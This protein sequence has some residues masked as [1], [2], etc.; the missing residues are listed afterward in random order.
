[1]KNQTKLNLLITLAFIVVIRST[2]FAQFG[3]IGAF[4]AAGADDAAKLFQP[5]ISPYMNAFGASLTGGWYNTAETHKLGG[6]DITLTFNVAM[7]PQKYNSFDISDIDLSLLQLDNPAE[8]ISPTIAGVKNAG[9]Q[10][11]YNLSGF[12][13]PAFTMPS[14]LN[15]KYVPSPML[16]AGLGLI[17]GT[18]VIGRYIPTIKFKGGEIGMWGIGGKHNIKQWIPGLKKL[19][20]LNLSILYGYTKL[21]MNAGMNITPENIG[22]DGLPGATSNA[23]DNQEMK[24]IVRSSTLNL[25]VSANLPVVCFYG[26]IGFVST[27]TTLKLEGDYPMVYLDGAIPSVQASVDPLDMTIKPEK[28]GSTKV[29]LNVGVRFKFAIVTVHFDYTRANYNVLTAGFGFSFR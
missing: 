5:Y 6:F 15:N 26:G 16:Q 24:M 4:M 13:Q 8:H 3:D 11:D 12:T 25:L 20:I 10:M 28:G 23:W 17:K 21:H 7:V 14:G 22:A 27:K 2:A 18:E 9:P 1:M 19:P 29:R